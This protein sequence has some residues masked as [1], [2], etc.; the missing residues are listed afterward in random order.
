MKSLQLLGLD[1]AFDVAELS[2]DRS[3]LLVLLIE[4]LRV[5]EVVDKTVQ[6]LQTSV[7]QIANLC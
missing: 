3:V 7:G 5:F 4:H 2:N 6:S 1:E